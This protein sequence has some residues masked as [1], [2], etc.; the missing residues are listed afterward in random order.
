MRTNG[1][2]TKNSNTMAETMV[3]HLLSRVRGTSDARESADSIVRSKAINSDERARGQQVLLEAQGHYMASHQYRLDRERNKKYNFGDQLSDIVCVDGKMMTEEAYIKKQGGVPLITNLI[4]RITNKVV[5]TFR[6]QQSEPLCYA[7]DRDEQKEA[8]ALSTLL[9][10]NMQLN[11]MGELYAAGMKEFYIGGMVVHKKSFGWRNE[12]MDCWTDVVPP[13]MFIVDS[14]MQDLRGWDCEFVG[15]LHDMSYEQ[16]CASLAQSPADYMKLAEIY[17]YARDVRSGMQTWEDFGYSRGTAY[18][19]FLQPK[20]ASRCRVIEVWRKESKPRYRCHDWNSGEMYKVDEEDLGVVM[21]ENQKRW[22]MAQRNGIPMEEVPFIEAEW[23]MDSYWYYYFLSPFGDILKEGETPYAHKSHPFA[24][25][26]YPFIDGE[27]HSPV[28]DLIPLQ[29]YVNNMNMTYNMIW[30]S[31]AKGLLAIPR[32]SMGN[33][34]EEQ[35]ASTWAKPNGVLVFDADYKDQMPF[36]ISTNATNIG[37]N[38]ML[39][40]YLQFF[41][42]VSGVNAAMQGKPSFAG[43]SGNHAQVMAQNAAT[44]LLDIIESYNDF[45]CDAEYKDLKNIQ[46]YYDEKKVLNIVGRTAAGA[47]INARK[48]LDTE[49]DI[50]IAPSKKTPI[51]RAMADEFYMTLFDKQAINLEQLLE[52]VSV[53]GSDELLQQVRSQRQQIEQGQMPQQPLSRDLIQRVQGG[54]KTDPEAM[55]LLQQAVGGEQQSA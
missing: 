13:N 48:V 26:A 36:Q 25:K 19:D 54:L 21:M 44:S 2:E 32:K 18:T 38:E 35:I 40:L 10:Y 14:N 8:E 4:N 6:E 37:I 15:Q 55:G 33:L 50:S 29:R 49:A 27:I 24:F 12:R 51:Y 22:E 1:N 7:R 39:S 23:F 41:D 5:G 47:N 53:Q 17:K 46:Q 42:D 20:D 31:S 34:T 11:R 52:R 30:R 16:V 9:Q 45:M 43:E 3:I 28:S